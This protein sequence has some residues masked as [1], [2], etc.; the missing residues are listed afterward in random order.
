VG[1]GTGRR[2]GAQIRFLIGKQG[3]DGYSN[4]AEQIAV[5]ARD[6]GMQVFYEGIRMTPEALVEAAIAQN[7][8]VIGLSVL[9]GSHL[10]LVRE[11]LERL[12]SSILAGIPVIVGG[13][14][15]DGDA[16]V[17]RDEGVAKVYT[18]KD[19]DLNRII[20]DIAELAAEPRR[21]GRRQA[22]AG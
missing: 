7:V 9:S 10:P 14:I 6:A 2:A 1:A 15:P 16:R 18:P 13:I 21:T 22:L 11:F 20:A 8:H 19:F 17:L 3:L 4:S 12:D 5:R